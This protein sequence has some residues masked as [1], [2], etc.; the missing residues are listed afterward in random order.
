MKIFDFA[1]LG[2]LLSTE[3]QDRCPAVAMPTSHILLPLST[4]TYVCCCCDQCSQS[5]AIRHCAVLSPKGPEVWTRSA[6]RGNS[7]PELLPLLAT[8]LIPYP[9]TPSCVAL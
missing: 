7:F 1:L 8:S 6:H 2:E 9:S 3:A 5:F 4:V